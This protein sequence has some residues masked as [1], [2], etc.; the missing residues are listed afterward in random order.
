MLRFI[1]KRKVSDRHSG[2]VTEHF[3]TIDIDAPDLQALLLRGGSG[4][5]EYDFTQLVGV[6]IKDTP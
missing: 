3:E 4:M 2:A 5:D 1:L 6:E